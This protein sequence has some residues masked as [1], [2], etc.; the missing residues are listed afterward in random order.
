MNDANKTKAEILATQKIEESISDIF[1]NENIITTINKCREVF[2]IDPSLFEKDKIDNGSNK[3]DNLIQL[4]LEHWSDHFTK[5]NALQL[6][7]YIHDNFNMDFCEPKKINR[8]IFK[9]IA[10]AILFGIPK[11][12]IFECVPAILISDYFPTINYHLQIQINELTTELDIRHIWPEVM[13]AQK[14]YQWSPKNRD[15][16]IF[17]HVKGKKEYP[18]R[19]RNDKIYKIA[20]DHPEFTRQQILDELKN[21]GYDADFSVTN[22]SVIL[23]REKKRRQKT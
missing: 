18:S 16:N 21:R 8:R 10:T 3:L 20:K 19:E 4:S 12:R 6:E 2:E 9:R 13:K 5:G 14:R 23:G 7:R 1:I 15:I 17:S 11:K 22:I